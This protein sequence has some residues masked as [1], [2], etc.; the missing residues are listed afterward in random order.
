MKEIDRP[1]TVN[2]LRELGLSTYESKVFVALQALGAASARDISETIDVPRSQVYGAADELEMKGLVESSKGTPKRYRSVGLDTASEW[3]RDR[4]AET[5]TTA[6]ADLERIRK[7]ANHVDETRENV[8]IIRG[9]DAVT[10]RVEELIARATTRVLFVTEH[11]SMLTDGIEARLREQAETGVDVFV[12][13]RDSTIASRF[14]D[15]AVTTV[16][17]PDQWPPRPHDARGVFVDTDAVLLS[18]L[19]PTDGDETTESAVWAADSKLAELFTLLVSSQFE[20]V[21]DG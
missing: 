7:R 20:L 14:D 15:D 19:E 2:A 11:S 4:F 10:D 5:H 18:V 16:S 8:W 6:F 9:T 13:T 1:Q 3:F 17:Y 12:A 21:T